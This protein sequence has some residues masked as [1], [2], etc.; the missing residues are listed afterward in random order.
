MNRLQ[1]RRFLI[2]PKIGILGQK[3]FPHHYLD[4]SHVNEMLRETIEQQQQSAC[5]SRPTSKESARV[6]S[7]SVHRNRHTEKL[8]SKLLSTNLNEIHK[9]YFKYLSTGTDASTNSVK[10]ANIGDSDQLEENSAAFNVE[11]N[12]SLQLQSSDNA[13]FFL[14][15]PASKLNANAENTS[16]EAISDAGLHGKA[17]AHGSNDQTKI[18]YQLSKIHSNNKKKSHHHHHHHH[19]HHHTASTSSKKS[20]NEYQEIEMKTLAIVDFKDENI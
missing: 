2:G 14:A 17:A 5:P 3:I 8:I 12:S 6:L 7:P 19:Y 18:I 9:N 16:T 15:R 1:Y 4:N 10:H 20:N 11:S 13:N